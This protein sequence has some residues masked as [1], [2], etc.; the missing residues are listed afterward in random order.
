MF[1][2]ITFFEEDV[3]IFEYLKNVRK[4]QLVGVLYNLRIVVAV[5]VINPHMLYYYHHHRHQQQHYKYLCETQN[6][7]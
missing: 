6:Q 2:L 3:E 5:V 4:L 1:E 7:N